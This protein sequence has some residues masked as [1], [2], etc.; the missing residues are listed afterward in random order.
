[1]NIIKL[2]IT[3]G[4]HHA[5][6]LAAAVLLIMIQEAVEIRGDQA[7]LVAEE[8]AVVNQQYICMN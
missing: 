5:L 4:V 1:M 6:V 7:A 3:E 8:A 2:V